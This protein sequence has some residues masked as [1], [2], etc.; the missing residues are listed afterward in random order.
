[1]ATL[2]PN[3]AE[4]FQ[5]LMAV[6]QAGWNYSPL[7]SNLTV[8][9]LSYILADAGVRAFVADERFAPVAARRRTKPVSRSPVDSRW[10]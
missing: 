2:L 9:E 7:N 3:R 1:M 4:V 6:H 10:V 8:D 5:T